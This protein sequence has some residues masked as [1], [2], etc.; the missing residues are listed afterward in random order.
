MKESDISDINVRLISVSELQGATAIN[1]RALRR[2]GGRTVSVDMNVR[3]IPDLNHS[4]VTLVV[5]CSY[6]AVIGLL[7]TRLLTCSAVTTFEVENLRKHI[8]TQGEDVVLG[9]KLMTLMLGIAVGALRGI[10]AYRT[11]D[12]PLRNTPLPI[13]DLNALMYRLRYGR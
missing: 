4:M 12:T 13:L 1:R 6:I 8:E 10:V 9:G 7:R 3:A 2:L 5:T 11:A